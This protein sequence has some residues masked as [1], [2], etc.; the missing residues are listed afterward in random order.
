MEAMYRSFNITIGRLMNTSKWAEQSDQRQKEKMSKLQ[1]RIEELTLI[2]DSLTKD[3]DKMNV[4]VQKSTE[5]RH[6]VWFCA[7][8]LAYIS[9]SL[10]SSSNNCLHLFLGGTNSPFS[11]QI[12][13]QGM[14]C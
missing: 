4:K 7:T 5:Q 14:S 1:A 10:S 13:L 8:L 3:L 11:L 6:L 2:V 12:P 9:A